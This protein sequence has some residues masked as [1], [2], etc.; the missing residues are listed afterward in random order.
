[1]LL[2]S[3]PRPLPKNFKPTPSPEGRRG[4]GGGVSTEK[5][6]H[7][8]AKNPF[9]NPTSSASMRPGLR[10]PAD[11][12]NP[13][14]PKTQPV[15]P[16]PVLPGRMGCPRHPRP[17]REA[18]RA[19]RRRLTWLG[20]QLRESGPVRAA[21]EGLA[22]ARTWL[23]RGDPSDAAPSPAEAREPPPPPLRCPGRGWGRRGPAPLC[24][25][26]GGSR[27][28]QL[29]RPSPR[30]GAGGWDRQ[31]WGRGPLSAKGRARPG[32]HVRPPPR[33]SPHPAEAG[34]PLPTRPRPAPARRGDRRAACGVCCSS[35]AP[36]RPPPLPAPPRPAPGCVARRLHNR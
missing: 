31:G 9:P 6:P 2:R 7:Q 17:A 36:P 14:A 18:H 29:G 30:P 4:S 24:S 23:G 12:W 3:A 16:T 27:Q 11:S 33:I 20:A 5:R 22:S 21:R 32:T 13:D 34:Q 35:P 28:G 19:P 1:M 10:G 25:R 8:D 26:A 15:R